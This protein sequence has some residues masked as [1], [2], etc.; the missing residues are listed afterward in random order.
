MQIKTGVYGCQGPLIE[1]LTTS[2]SII[3]TAYSTLN[4]NSTYDY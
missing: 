4:Q 1:M 2:I 3:L